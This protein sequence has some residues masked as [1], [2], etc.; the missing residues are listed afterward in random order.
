MAMAKNIK[1]LLSCWEPRSL[2]DYQTLA[3]GRS[4]RLVSQ[5]NQGNTQNTKSGKK[6]K[7]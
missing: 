1:M 2:L 7:S 3:V 4:V 5:V 6:G